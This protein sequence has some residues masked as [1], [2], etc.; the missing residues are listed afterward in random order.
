MPPA[1]AVG[2]DSTHARP[3]SRG[4]LPAAV[5]GRGLR[6]NGRHFPKRD[7]QGF[8]PLSGC[9][10]SPPVSPRDGHGK[11]VGVEGAKRCAG[12]SQRNARASMQFLFPVFGRACQPFLMGKAPQLPAL[13]RDTPKTGALTLKRFCPAGA[14]SVAS[15]HRQRI[16]A[17]RGKDASFPPPVRSFLL[18][19]QKSGQNRIKRKEQAA[20]SAQ[21]PA[22]FGRW[23]SGK[24][25]TVSG[26]NVRQ[27]R[28]LRAVKAEGWASKCFLRTSSR[29]PR[30][31]M[32][33]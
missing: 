6:G 1:G 9:G 4:R 7:S 5:G 21:G 15:A 14:N 31:A 29:G 12:C 24:T 3:T 25:V 8:G 20:A 2:S 11:T 22:A 32:P 17:P 28:C 10:Q 19:H 18:L 26:E 23:G 16:L 27:A 30:K 13:P 33:V